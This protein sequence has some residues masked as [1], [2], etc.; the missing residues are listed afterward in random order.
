MF[1]PQF[2]GLKARINSLIVKTTSMPSSLSETSTFISNSARDKPRIQP[3]Y[4]IKEPSMR[5]LPERQA[6][7]PTV[8]VVTKHSH[9]F[10]CSTASGL[11]K[12]GQLQFAEVVKGWIIETAPLIKI[13]KSNE[14]V[15]YKVVFTARKPYTEHSLVLV[16][17]I[18]TSL[19]TA[20]LFAVKPTG[21]GSDWTLVERS[22]E[23]DTLIDAVEDL[24]ERVMHRA[25]SLAVDGTKVGAVVKEGE[26]TS[27]DGKTMTRKS[28]GW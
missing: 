26:K 13:L 22:G 25:G 20:R 4:P 3:K 6:S 27:R 12:L 14:T 16:S 2:A 17:V 10:N 21:A 1:V 23:T 15:S 11:D 18:A 7:L 5:L 24:W 8:N 9:A 28:T 19:Y